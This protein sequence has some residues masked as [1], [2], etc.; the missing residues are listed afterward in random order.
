VQNSPPSQK[1]N[2]VIYPSKKE[3]SLDTF[4]FFVPAKLI[5]SGTPGEPARVRGVISTEDRDI[6][7]EILKSLDY[8]ILKS[9]FGKIKFE[10]DDENMKEPYNIIGAP[11]K[12]IQKGTETF[13][14]GELFYT[15]GTPDAQ[16]NT[17][18]KLAKSAYDLLENIE[19]FNKRN[20]E[21]PQRIGWSVEGQYLAKDKKTGFVK[22]RVVNV[23][24]TTKPRNMHTFAEIIRKSLEVGYGMTPDTQTG[25]GATR[26]E[27]ISNNFNNQTGDLKMNKEGIYKSCRAKGLSHEEAVKEANEWE[28]KK[29]KE[30][31]DSYG[32]AEKSLNSTK[33]ALKKSISFADEALTMDVD[34]EV[35]ELEKSMK[36]SLAT[37]DKGEIDDL[38][39]F[40]K[41][42]KDVTLRIYD[43]SDKIFNQNLTLAKSIKSL[44]EAGVEKID[45][46]EFMVK[47]LASVSGEIELQRNGLITLTNVLRKSSGGRLLTDGLQDIKVGEDG[48]EPEALLSKAQKLEVLNQLAH[49]NKLD[50]RVVTM[51]ESTN[52]LAPQ[53]EQLIKS[54]LNNLKK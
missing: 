14:E 29:N 51:Y 1:A 33:E 49:E 30:M 35:E 40:L 28:S 31:N 45:Q 23:V 15:P 32:A 24:L 53:H 37:N 52:V 17:Q 48:K 54:T 26:K 27:S 19:N 5:K 21:T 50:H 6:D 20:P 13:F 3:Q 8:S 44:A 43:A 7:K 36:K 12:V 22:A 41:L 16:L 39:P 47:S 4:E 46:Q 18:Q 2:L 42:L 38:G 25:F 11:I 9:G 34:F 10:H